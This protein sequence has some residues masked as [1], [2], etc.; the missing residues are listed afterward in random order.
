MA[1]TDDLIYAPLKDGLC[2]VAVLVDRVDEVGPA[3]SALVGL[4]QLSQGLVQ[5]DE[6]TIFVHDFTAKLPADAKVE[7]D[8]SRCET[9]HEQTSP[10]IL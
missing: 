5:E 8:C 9:L 1:L 6:A 4:S 2:Q 10:E 3:V 7:V